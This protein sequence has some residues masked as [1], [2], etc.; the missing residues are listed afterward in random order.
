[1][2]AANSWICLILLWIAAETNGK[3]PDVQLTCIFSEDCVLPCVFEAVGDEMIY[4]FRQN[5]P[6]Q[7]YIQGSGRLDQADQQYNSRTSLF[8][9]MIP[10]GN[11]S[12]HIQKCGP[13]DRGKYR[14]LVTS[15]QE[16]TEQFI[17]V[18]V[19]APIQSVSLETTRL[20]GFEEVICSSQDA[21]PAPRVN[22]FTE[23]ASLPDSLQPFTRKTADKQGLYS[24]ESKLKK[25]K[26]LTYICL[27]Q[28]F[29]RSQTWRASLQEKETFS[30]EGQD[31]IIPCV[32]PWKLQNFTLTWSFTKE[33]KSSTIYTY[34]S[35]TQ[36]SSSVWKE[37]MRLVTP[38]GRGGDG[39]LQLH[40]PLSLEH[41]GTYTCILYAHQTKHEVHTRVNITLKPEKQQSESSPQRWIPAVIT[42]LAVTAVAAIIGIIK[43]G[44]TKSSKIHGEATEMQ[45]MRVTVANSRAASEDTCL[46]EE[47]AN[48]PA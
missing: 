39:S 16:T 31:L 42:G 11:A 7:S 34:D 9:E 10:S 17:I 23:P 48:R 27:V 2:T 24:V 25:L 22:L 1:M 20:S 45:P 36:R 14:C 4:W 41:T 12:L 38:R 29:Y 46:T 13:Q 43:S 3:T 33:H 44:C 5:V 37:N 6:I 26:D 30:V 19:E 28:S 47:I 35:L 21:Y 32:A 8:T 40:N 18:K 15:S